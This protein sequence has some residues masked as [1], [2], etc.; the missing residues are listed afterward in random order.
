MPA[1]VWKGYL[2]FGLVSFPVRL[3]AAARAE[4]AHFHLL[5]RKDRSRVK[6]A[7]YCNPAKSLV[8]HMSRPFK[9]AALHDSYQ[10][11]LERL[12]EEK[13]KEQRITAVKRPRRAPAVDWMEALK[14]SLKTAS[15]SEPARK[16][17]GRHK[18][19]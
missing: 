8:D 14:R 6:E 11:N 15:L 7:W 17:S 1:T 13:R 19:A 9:P 5:H 2:S 3:F 16:G 4:P 12:I 18:A 10:E